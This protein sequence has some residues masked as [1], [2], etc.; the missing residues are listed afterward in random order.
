MRQKEIA[1]LRRQ[2]Q[3]A[4]TAVRTVFGC[5]VNDGKQI[6]STFDLSLGLLTE[7]E[8]TMYLGLLKKLFSGAQG[9]CLFDIPFST[10]QVQDSPEHGLLMRL[11]GSAC[12]DEISRSELFQR[13]AETVELHI[14]YV[15]LL[16]A[17]SYDVPFRGKDDE[18]QPDASDEVFSYFMCA[19][20]PVKQGKAALTYNSEERSFRAANGPLLLTPP[21]LGFSFPAFD[22]RQTNLYSALYYVKGAE[23]Y[24]P[25][26]KAIF[27]ADPPKSA[28]EQKEAFTAALNEL[29]EECS[30]DVVNAVSSHLTEVI[31]AHKENK[32]PEPL[33]ISRHE[34]ESVLEYQGVSEEKRSAF[35]HALECAFGDEEIRPSVVVDPRKCEIATPDVIIQTSADSSDLV[36]IRIID[37]AKCIVIRVEGAVEVN[38]VDIHV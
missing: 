26:V 34:I 19:L 25:F 7:E 6:V 13:I 22:D 21:I 16:A 14:S 31:A 27:N 29:Q 2:L 4:R 1:E 37:G 12:E 33:T 30:L 28:Q 23:M 5:Y 8:S 32:D 10:R 18:T 20:C 38:G 17:N 3:P 36:E 9:R 35:S 24:D 11:R 15:I